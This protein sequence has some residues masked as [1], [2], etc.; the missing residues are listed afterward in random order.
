M[1]ATTA[2]M[3]TTAMP[4]E[5]TVPCQAVSP[6]LIGVGHFDMTIPVTMIPTVVPSAPAPIGRVI[7]RVGVTGHGSAVADAL[8][9][10]G[11]QETDTDQE[12][13]RRRPSAA[14]HRNHRCSSSSIFC[15]RLAIVG[16]IL[17]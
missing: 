15:A 13:Q 1:A 9:A 4:A 3:S 11:Q 6:P 2:S 10:S 5:A 8:Y 16:Y 7:C 17:S 14:I 12:G